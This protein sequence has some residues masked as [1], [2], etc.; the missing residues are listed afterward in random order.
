[1][2]QSN[3]SITKLTPNQAKIKIENF[4]AYQ[5]RSQQEVRNKLYTWGLSSYDV[6]SI[7][8]QL[9]EDNFL[10]E[11]R[12]ALAYAIGKFKMKGWGKYKIKQGLKFKGVSEPLIKIALKKIQPDEYY[13]KLNDIIHKKRLTLKETDPYKIRFKLSQ[14]AISRGYE[15]ELIREIIDN[16][17]RV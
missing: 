15:T 10:N 16:N 5:E 9:I 6:E 1:M 8:S 13:Q 2:D 4:C 3:K 17:E 12:F 7:I 11:E 14:Y